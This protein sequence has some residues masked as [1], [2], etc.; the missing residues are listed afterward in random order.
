MR[1]VPSITI[2]QDLLHGSDGADNERRRP[3]NEQT[4]AA[5]N[6][7]TSEDGDPTASRGRMAGSDGRLGQG[8]GRFQ[9]L[10]PMRDR[11]GVR[12]RNG[13]YRL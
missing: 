7:G 6:V 5:R 3:P 11:D 10:Y 12:S 2:M 8:P 4:V 1:Q 9:I 13:A